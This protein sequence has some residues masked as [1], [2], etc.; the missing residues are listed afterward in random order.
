[1]QRAII[2][3]VILLIIGWTGLLSMILP[4]TQAQQTVSTQP[5]AVQARS[6]TMKD[7]QSRRIAIESMTDIDPSLK[8]GS[9]DYIN[10]AIR[11][12][13][14]ADV[15]HKKTIALSQLIQTA[16]ERMKILQAELKKP[17]TATEK[18]EAR[19]QNMS[20]LKLEQ[21][22]T[23]KE[24]E[25]ATAQ[26]NLKQWRERLAAEKTIIKQTPEKIAFA[27][28]RLK[29]IQTELDAKSSID[30]KDILN[31]SRML[32]FMAERENLTSEIKFNEQR[33]RSHNLLLE[34]YSTEL[35]VARLVV[36]SREEML[37]TW[38]AEV[39]NR[40]QQ[41]AVQVKEG[42]QE[43][44]G[45]VPLMPKVVQDQFDINIKLST[46][47]EKITREESDLAKKFQDFQTHL[48]V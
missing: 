44:I 34:L 18:V 14:L 30:E 48:K 28:G 11:Y 17:F 35:E 23:Q 7:L 32:G 6:V 9:L 3:I 41:E 4:E 43:A 36:K 33:Q 20:T 40:R 31:H 22:L 37:K 10:R 47:L 2:K 15:T 42:A 39:L 16:P 19:A 38:Q 45:E 25:L 46:E 5:Q 1:M 21:R 13:E 8:A 27:T 12:L 24:A 26:S 29:E